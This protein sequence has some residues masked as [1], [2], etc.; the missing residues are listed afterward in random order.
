M[1]LLEELL[2]KVNNPMKKLLLIIILLF[3]LTIM[4]STAFAQGMMGSLS[5]PSSVTS[6]DHTAREEAEGKEIWE[7]LQAKQLECKNLTDE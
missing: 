6:D 1:K 5:L 4:P 7:K 2:T 3:T